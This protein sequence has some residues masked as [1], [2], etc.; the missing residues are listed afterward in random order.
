MTVETS[1]THATPGVHYLTPP[2]A[3]GVGGGRD[4]AGVLL[5]KMFE[6]R[7]RTHR[8]PPR[9]ARRARPANRALLAGP[10][11]PVRRHRAARS[12][13]PPPVNRAAPPPVSKHSDYSQQSSTEPEQSPPSP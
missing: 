11:A 3:R 12:A 9:S 1:K 4:A 7:V 10:R 8:P 6:C 13:R 5:V 2:D